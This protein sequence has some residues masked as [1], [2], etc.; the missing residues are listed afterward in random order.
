M[1]IIVSNLAAQAGSVD[2]KIGSQRLDP[3]SL[4]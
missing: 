2:T 3:I 4:T 1:R